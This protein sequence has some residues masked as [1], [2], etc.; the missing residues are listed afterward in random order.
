MAS[1]KDQLLDHDYDGIKEFDNPL[2]AWWL[3][4]FYGTIIFGIVYVP[5]YHLFGGKSVLQE[6]NEEVAL[7]EQQ[8]AETAKAAAPTVTPSSADQ[9]APVAAVA[10]SGGDLDDG[11]QIYM[12]NCLPCHGASGEGGIGPNLTDKFW[13]HGNTTANLVE[14]VTNGVPSMGM[15]SWKAILNPKKISNV[16]AY[17]QALQGTNP[18]NAKAPQGVEYP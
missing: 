11:K 15:I 5:Y 2:P 3:W 13:L 12:A 16:V 1:Q 7:V 18:P 17:I 4:L 10:T 6:Y 14:V 8:R 9:S